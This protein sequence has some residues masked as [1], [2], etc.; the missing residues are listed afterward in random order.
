MI[1]DTAGTITTYPLRITKMVWAEPVTSGDDL[2][3]SDSDGNVIWDVNATGVGT[4]T[5]YEINFPE[6]G[7]YIPGL[8]LTTI[9]SGQ[10]RVY[11]A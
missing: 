4:G 1:L 9:D 7:L 11:L 10:L 3:V 6:K 2:T 8:T 5:Y